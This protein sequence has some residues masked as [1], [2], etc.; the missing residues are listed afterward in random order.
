MG[1]LEVAAADLGEGICAA[2][3]STG[4]RVAVASYRPLIRCRL[5]GP[6]DPAQTASFR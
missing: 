5:P 3:A 2:I 4:V 1:L 6:Q